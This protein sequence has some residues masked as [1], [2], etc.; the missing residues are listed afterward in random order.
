MTDSINSRPQML[1]APVSQEL[2]HHMIRHFIELMRRHDPPLI[3]HGKR[4]AVYSVLIGSVMGVPANTLSDLSHAGLLHDLGKLTLPNELICQNGVSFFGE[5]LMEECIPQA[6][7]AI[8]RTWPGLQGIATLIALHHEHWDGS[9]NPFGMRGVLVPL[10]ARILSL[11]DIVDQFLTQ[12]DHTRK[13]QI[14]SL[15]RVLRALS[16]TRFDP[17][18]V[19]VAVEVLIPWIQEFN[20]YTPADRNWSPNEGSIAWRQSYP[21]QASN[22]DTHL[23]NIMDLTNPISYVSIQA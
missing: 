4:T 15:V 18:V 3:E 22:I 11:A 19:E 17:K 14:D 6:G 5:Y 1:R 16:E 21:A 8:L 12:K 10:G 7:A 23:K 13:E 2:P 9:G 20:R